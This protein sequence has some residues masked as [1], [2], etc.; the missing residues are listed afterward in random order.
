MNGSTFSMM[1]STLSTTMQV[2]PV[3][4][5]DDDPEAKSTRV[6]L[7]WLP[8]VILTLVL[9]AMALTSFLHYHVNNKSRYS[10]KT[11]VAQKP[12]TMKTPPVKYRVTMSRSGAIRPVEFNILDFPSKFAD[13]YNDNNETDCDIESEVEKSPIEKEHKVAL[14]SLSYNG[15]VTTIPTL[16]AD[17]IHNHVTVVPTSTGNGTSKLVTVLPKSLHEEI[18]NHVTILPTSHCDGIH[19]LVKMSPKLSHKRMQDQVTVLSRSS[20]DSV[21]NPLTKRKSNEDILSTT[22]YNLQDGNSCQPSHKPSHKSVSTTSSALSGKRSKALPTSHE[23]Y[24]NEAYDSNCDSDKSLISQRDN[25]RSEEE[26]GFN[27][28]SFDSSTESFGPS[29]PDNNKGAQA[30]PGEVKDI[31]VVPDRVSQSAVKDRLAPDTVY[32]QNTSSRS[33]TEPDILIHAVPK[34]KPQ[35][36]CTKKSAPKIGFVQSTHPKKPTNNGKHKSKYTV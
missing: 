17:G 12:Q 29:D 30:L 22:A 18:P 9:L 19:N 15:H 1:T 7:I 3:G 32:Y 23:A 16:S 10:S 34:A 31:S 20:N 8:Y 35:A 24:L 13:S 33:Y 26:F 6:Q 25:R 28:E 2:L 5:N 14:S 4:G 21:H 11:K 27:N 36:S